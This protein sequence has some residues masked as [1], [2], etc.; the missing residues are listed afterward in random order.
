MKLLFST[1]CILALLFP[2]LGLAA[3]YS[4]AP[5]VIDEEL[6]KR[7]IVTKTITLTNTESRNV[8]IFPTVNAVEVEEGGTVR[9][10]IEPSM[11]EDKAGEIT[12]WIEITRSRIELGPNESK[13]IPLTIKVHPEVQA[14]EYHAFIGFPEGSNRPEAERV[15]K[16]GSA[17]GTVV[18][19]G[20]GT[21]QSQF[22]RLT[23][24]AVERFVRDGAPG[25]IT[26]SLT[27]PGT[28]P[29]I[30][31][32][33]I[34]IYNN[35]GIEVGAVALNQS[36]DVIAGKEEKSFTAEV[37]QGLGLGKYKAFLTIEYG[38]VQKTSI[39]DTAFF[40]VVPLRQLLIIFGSILVLTALLAFIVHR[41]FDR[42]PVHEGD[43]KEVGLYIRT[44]RSEP[45]DHDI[46]LSK[47]NT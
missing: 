18:R 36:K 12:S 40:Y 10:F 46:D 23:S 31:E 28:D 1:L 13:E 2:S 25:V 33:E 35:R 27:N 42:E 30:P 16:N 21:V 29:V 8:R 38:L 32:G 4:V 17:P 14:G 39:N 45:K 24:Y 20:V 34:I 9:A 26:Y 6:Q 43:I 19:I 5:L 22:L 37:P 3:T 11:I 15:V 41:R 44:S 7:D 47:K